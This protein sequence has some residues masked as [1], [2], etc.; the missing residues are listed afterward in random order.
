MI[1]VISVLLSDNF[2]KYPYL[3]NILNRLIKKQE[4]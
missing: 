3:R 4:I 1:Y 2:N